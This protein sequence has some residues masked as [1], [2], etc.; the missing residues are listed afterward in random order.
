VDSDNKKLTI[1]IQEMKATLYRLQEQNQIKDAMDIHQFI[2]PT[3][4]RVKDPIDDANLVKDIIA[5]YSVNLDENPDEAPD[6]D[7]DPIILIHPA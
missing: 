6:I 1:T 4:E 3:S 7:P 2:D 5:N